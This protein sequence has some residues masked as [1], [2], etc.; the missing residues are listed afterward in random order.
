MSV[1]IPSSLPVAASLLK[2]AR[3]PEDV[4]GK[5]GSVIQDIYRELAKLVHED[6]APAD[7]K[8]I[9]HEAFILLTKLYEA[10][11]GKVTK[12]TYG[13]GKGMVVATLRTKTAA[14]I[15]SSLLSSDDIAD[16]YESTIE[17]S[18]TKAL[19]K[20]VRSPSNNDLMRME[21]DVLAKVKEEITDPQM[22]SY[23]PTLI[24]S[25]EVGAGRARERANVFGWA[26]GMITLEDVHSAIPSLDPR[27]AAWMWNRL[28]EALHFL[29]SLGYIHGAVT[30]DSFLINPVTHRGTLIN[31]CYATKIGGVVK[32]IS[33]RWKPEYPAEILEK[34]PVD[35]STDIYMAARCLKALIA[36]NMPDPIAALLKA[37]LLGRAHRINSAR[38]LHEDFKKTLVRLYGPR[39]FKVFEWPPKKG[40]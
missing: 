34:H 21:A 9:A 15:L 37:C 40:A 28:I 12:G 24:D 23:F 31:F 3:C 17:G 7:Q 29:H 32:A 30:P 26:E 13:D 8:P 38:D 35:T 2:R 36:N 25:F 1:A 20:L 16:F 27:D 18:D 33:P 6:L 5:D 39:A 19:V 22:L 4:F 14:Y 11:Q 10:A